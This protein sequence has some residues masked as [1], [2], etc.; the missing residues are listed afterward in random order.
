MLIA[1]I[2]VLVSCDK[3][4]Q[5]PENLYGKWKLTEQLADPGNGSGTWQKVTGKAKYV[6]FDKEGALTGEALPEFI[7]FKIIDT[8]RI[9]FAQKGTADSIIY[10]YKIKGDDLILNPPC[11]EACGIKFVKSE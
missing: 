2:G 10:Y 7:K 3:N 11:I 5:S 8:V 1:F 6:N 9:Q 4:D